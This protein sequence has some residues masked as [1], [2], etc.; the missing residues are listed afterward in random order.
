MCEDSDAITVVHNNTQDEIDH[1]LS[2][3]TNDDFDFKIQKCFL[4]TFIIFSLFGFGFRESVVFVN[5][6]I[7]A[8]RLKI[9]P[10]ASIGQ[11]QKLN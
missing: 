6:I 10:K 5:R 4:F 1:G 8:F 7:T 11:R 2:G 9:S 3:M